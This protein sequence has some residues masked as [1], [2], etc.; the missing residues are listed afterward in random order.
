MESD[1]TRI[2]RIQAYLENLMT[3]AEQSA[4]QI[5]LETDPSLRKELEDLRKA[6]IAVEAYAQMKVREEVAAAFA[7]VKNEQQAANGRR[8]Y[9]RMAAIFLLL[10]AASFSFILLRN[11]Y[12]PARMYK[13]SFELYPNRIGTMGSASGS[14]PLREGMNAYSLGEFRKALDLL[15]S[16]GADHPAKTEARFYEAQSL[17]ALNETDAAADAFQTLLAETDQFDE[18]GQWYLAL[19]YLKQGNET[20]AKALLS[21]ISTTNGHYKQEAASRML[22]KLNSFWRKI[23]G[24]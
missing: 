20:A 1:N 17:M 22:T 24:I 9:L 15:Q 6:R 3:P 14:D 7:H 11:T 23:P 10:V 4:F 13:S 21:E 2:E 19:A 8:T 16:V 5:E 12:D 18:P